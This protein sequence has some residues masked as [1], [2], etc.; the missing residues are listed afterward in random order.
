M[1][2]TNSIST[3]SNVAKEALRL[4]DNNLVFGSL[5]NRAYEA[6]FDKT[7]NGY[8]VGSTINIRKP[9]RYTVR[10]GKTANPQNSTEKTITLAVDT[11]EGVDMNFTS[12][13]LTL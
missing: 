8:K 13:D 6:E 2:A 7:P 10:P 12:A 5:V 9:A 1:T 3:V 4:L 11:Q